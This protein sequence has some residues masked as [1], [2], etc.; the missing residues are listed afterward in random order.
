[1]TIGQFYD[2]MYT[3]YNIS[4]EQ[5]YKGLGESDTD[6]LFSTVMNPKMR[7]LYRFTINDM[8]SCKEVLEMLHGKTD[9]MREKRRELLDN[10]QIS[11]ADIDN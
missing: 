10:A 4:I 7:K 8:D 5:R 2:E 1:M 9:K 11:Y 3:R 6:L